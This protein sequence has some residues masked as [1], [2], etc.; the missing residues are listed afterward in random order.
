MEPYDAQQMITGKKLW[1]HVCPH[2]IPIFSHFH[3]PCENV[4][5]L[6]SLYP[7]LCYDDCIAFGQWVQF[8]VLTSSF[9]FLFPGVILSKGSWPWLAP[10]NSDA[11]SCIALYGP[12]WPLIKAFQWQRKCGVQSAN[13]TLPEKK[14][15][16]LCWSGESDNG[17]VR[18]WMDFIGL[19]SFRLC[20]IETINNHQRM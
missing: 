10:R 5:S 15:C 18:R 19:L 2:R 1:K 20:L 7:W 17:T 8:P 9:L 12:G 3:R 11:A 14:N 13:H 6:L 4:K 16:L